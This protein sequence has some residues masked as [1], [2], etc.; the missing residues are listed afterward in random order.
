[1]VEPPTQLI[2]AGELRVLVEASRENT[3]FA[4]VI[5]RP[6][7]APTLPP[8]VRKPSAMRGLLWLGALAIAARE[9]AM[10]FY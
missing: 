7:R 8:R 2:A 1:M 4:H 9:L 5:K 6:G 10:L 3:Q